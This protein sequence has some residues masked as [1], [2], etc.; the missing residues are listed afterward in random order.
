MGGGGGVLVNLTE[1][2]MRR[3]T[4]AIKPAQWRVAAGFA[5]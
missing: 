3:K 5:V 4:I 2:G 1:R